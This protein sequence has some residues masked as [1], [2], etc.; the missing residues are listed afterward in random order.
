M[1]VDGSQA[2]L[3]AIDCSQREACLALLHAG[4]VRERRFDPAA[5]FDREVLWDELRAL[6]RDVGVSVTSLDA[7]AV[8]TGPGGFTGLRVAVA[9]AKGIAFARGI[10]VV[11]VPSAV[12][13][14]ASDRARGG[15]SPWLIALAAKNG[16]AWVVEA[17]EAPSGDIALSEPE[18]AGAERFAAIAQGVVA[19]G[20]VLLADE[21]LGDALTQVAAVHGLPIRP[22]GVDATAFVREAAAR[23]Q[24]G[25]TIDPLALSP[26][27]A[28]E[29]EAVTKWRERALSARPEA[30]GG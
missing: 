30:R 23:L 4:S 8:A 28:R 24:R 7:V 11:E 26:I 9:S 13:F 6:F 12:V 1:T 29:P 20:G 19:R 16:T 2:T 25:I 18:V 3:L 5:R 14:A 10:P 17:I 21:H 27:Y 22:F 15:R